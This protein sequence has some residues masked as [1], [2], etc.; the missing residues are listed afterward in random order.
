M[1]LGDFPSHYQVLG[2]ITVHPDLDYSPFV[3]SKVLLLHLEAAIAFGD[4]PE[5][6]KC[7]LVEV[8]VVGEGDVFDVGES[9]G[10]PFDEEGV[11]MAH[12]AKLLFL[13]L[14]EVETRDH[15]LVPVPEMEDLF[16][17]FE[18]FLAP[19]E[20]IVLFDLDTFFLAIPPEGVVDVL[21]D[22]FP[23][24]PIEGVVLVAFVAHLYCFYF[25]NYLNLYHRIST[26]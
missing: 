23:V 26:S 19:G 12:G 6:D 5:A 16:L 13:L 25:M 7:L 22:E 3:D 10:D 8:E 21:L 11:A 15:F 24:V 4:V 20:N 18:L 9:D 2:E 17:L 1:L 14:I